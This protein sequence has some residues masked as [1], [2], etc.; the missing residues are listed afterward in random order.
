[1]LSKPVFSMSASGYCPKRQSARLLGTIE[2][3]APPKWLQS[4]AEEGNWH[5][6]RLKAELVDEGCQILD[7]QRE[8]VLHYPR[9]D[10]VGHIDGRTKLTKK[11]VQIGRAHV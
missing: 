3:S 1:M 2:P 10:L 5:E 6:A 4:S 9:F 7:E 8:L 11:L